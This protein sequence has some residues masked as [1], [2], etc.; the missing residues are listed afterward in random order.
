M[1]RASRPVHAYR[2]MVCYISSR[3]LIDKSDRVVLDRS[4]PSGPPAPAHA[5]G[6]LH[7]LD[8]LRAVAVVVVI[9]HHTRGNAVPGILQP[10]HSYGWMGVDLFFVLSGYLIGFQ[11]LRHYAAG[12]T[13]SLVDFYVRRGFRILPAYMLVLALY[14]AA[15]SLREQLEMVPLWRFLSFTMNLGF[16]RSEGAAFS[17]AWSLCVEEH[18]YLLFPLVCILLMRRPSVKGA[19]VAIGCIVAAGGAV[20]SFSWIWFVDPVLHRLGAD[21]AMEAVYPEYIYYPTYTRLDGLLVGVTL[22]GI[23]VFRPGWWAWA[24]RRGHG[25]ELAGLALVAYAVWLFA[26]RVSLAGSLF[27]FPILSVGL[28]LLLASGVSANGVLARVRIPGAATLA[29]LAYSLYLTH[30]AVMHLDRLL[31]ADWLPLKGITGL[32]IYG[33]SSCA[34]AVALY[35]LVERPF[36]RFRERLLPGRS[37]RGPS[38]PRVAWQKSP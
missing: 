28:G 9:L 35:L 29:M 4:R 37:V 5:G 1:A 2:I 7:G 19:A 26:D 16:D 15:P 31:L 18:F 3:K 33:A 34:V 14:Y 24:M 23:K 21:A 6:R 12:R 8:S 11:L 36:L 32:A 13:P 10:I 38:S 17:H 27:G 22:A 20:R 25:L 30:K